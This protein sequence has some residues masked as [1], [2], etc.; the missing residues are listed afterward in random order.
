MLPKGLKDPAS[1]YDR[2][3]MVSVKV[4]D[5]DERGKISLSMKAAKADAEAVG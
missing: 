5:I 4:L 3:D 2:D 1:E